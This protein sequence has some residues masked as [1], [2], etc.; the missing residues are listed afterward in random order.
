ME[1]RREREAEGGRTGEP[2]QAALKLSDALRQRYVVG[3][4]RGEVDHP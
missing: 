4:E 3:R 2:R 1:G